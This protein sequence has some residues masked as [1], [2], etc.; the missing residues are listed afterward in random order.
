MKKLGL[1][2]GIGPESTSQYYQQIVRH[3]REVLATTDYPEFTVE[4]INMTEMLSFLPSDPDG[5]VRF[6]LDRIKTLEGSG[7][8]FAALASNTP[9]IV[10]DQLEQ[11]SSIPL[12]SIVRITCE[13][14][15]RHSIQSL[16]LFGTKS[17]MS[18][19]FYQEVGKQNGLEIYTPDDAEQDYIHEKYFS[20]LVFNQKNES[21]K[22]G[23]I[24]IANDLQRRCKIQG[25]ILGGTELPLVLDQAD[26]DSIKVFDTTQIHVKE[27]VKR[28][29]A[30]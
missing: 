8:H 26:F 3:Y 20:E 29:I 2:G 1:I 15:A 7:A 21:T 5:L 27:L 28:M 17:T 14:I 30:R 18:T 11:Q 16:G 12:V 25:L 9:H 6:L 22:R 23:L 19:G 13:E 10:F 24:A 4:S